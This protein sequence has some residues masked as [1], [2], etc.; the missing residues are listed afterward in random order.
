MMELTRAVFEQLKAV[1]LTRAWNG[2]GGSHTLVTYP[3][4]DALNPLSAQSV[5]PNL[6]RVHA[7][8]LY[9]HIPFCEMSCAFCPYETH[10][11]TQAVEVARYLDALKSEIRLVARELRNAE[12]ISVY[13]GGG[14]ATVLS[15]SQL[16]G[17]LK[18]LR[19]YFRFSANALI[20]VETSPNALI[21]APSKIGLLH[22]LG[23]KRVSIGVQTFSEKPL[24]REGRTHRPEETLAILERLVGE[25]DVVNIDLMQDMSGQ[26]DD[27]LAEDCRQI[28]ALG[29]SQV[30]WYVERLRK[31]RGDF[32]DSYQSVVRRL[33]LRDAMTDLGYRPRPGGRFVFSGGHDDGFKNIRCGLNSHLVGL[34]ASAYSHVPNVFY[35]NVVDTASYIK[36]VNDGTLPIAAGTPLRKL[37]VVAGG[38]ASG[39]RW[40]AALEQ[41]DPDV[42]SYVDD[43]RVRLEILMHFDLV[44]F[45]PT[46]KQY[47]ITLDGP[48]W[49][50]EEEICS[51]F[52]PQDIV[53][54]IRAKGLP[55]WT[56][57]SSSLSFNS[58][59]A[60][61]CVAESMEL[62]SL[63][64]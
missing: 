33:W 62:L 56:S 21:E 13:I 32:P 53:D 2:L 5:L 28:A 44:H 35:R 17:L 40:G 1:G 54:Q 63:L 42:S 19:D 23:V 11:V 45:D 10:V 8:N 46:T 24:R 57:Q 18:E 16:E 48:G 47:Q 38:F 31:W 7:V 37:D 14:T 64:I 34:G 59:V 27:D 29:P 60:M 30:T 39:I 61:L 49:A 3:P 15:A 55:W 9:V 51:L 52:V 43:V 25:I 20:C 41:S 50:Y 12:V 58:T 6:R 36:A 4:L 22:Q 26:T